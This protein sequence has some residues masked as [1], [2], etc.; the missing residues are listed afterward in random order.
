MQIQRK[1][2]YEKKMIRFLPNLAIFSDFPKFKVIGING[3]FS[4]FSFSK[5][6]WG[7]VFSNL[8]LFSMSRFILFI[9][10]NRVPYRILRSFTFRSVF[11]GFYLKYL[12]NF[13]GYI[14]LNSSKSFMYKFSNLMNVS[15][16]RVSCFL[17]RKFFN[18]AI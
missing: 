17:L 15:F 7:S 5:Y 2:R 12:S 4:T 16:E 14:T 6:D 3:R 11:C 8:M 13:K 9:V 10:R 18:T 1:Y